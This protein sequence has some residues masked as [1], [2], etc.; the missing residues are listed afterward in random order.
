MLVLLN[1]HQKVT[2]SLS[3]IWLPIPIVLV[4]HSPLTSRTS[5]IAGKGEEPRIQKTQTLA[6]TVL[7]QGVLH[8]G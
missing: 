3:P 4:L 6:T 8:K 2:P 1:V 7:N 5:Q